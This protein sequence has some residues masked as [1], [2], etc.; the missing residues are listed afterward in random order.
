[1]SPLARAL[2]I[3]AAFI[4]FLLLLATFVPQVEAAEPRVQTSTILRVQP[5][6]HRTTFHNGDPIRLCY[7]TRTTSAY[8]APVAISVDVKQA[9]AGSPWETIGVAQIAANNTRC[10]TGQVNARGKDLIL[11]ARTLTGPDHDWSVSSVLRLEIAS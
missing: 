10:F 9:V 11:R 4:V 3:L 5:G 8:D 2:A 6:V 7:G 1:M